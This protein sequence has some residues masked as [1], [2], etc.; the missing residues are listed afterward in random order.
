LDWWVPWPKF[1]KRYVSWSQPGPG[2]SHSINLQ[3]S[4]NLQ[5]IGESKDQPTAASQE[6]RFPLQT[7]LILLIMLIFHCVSDQGLT[8]S[9]AQNLHNSQNPLHVGSKLF[10]FHE[11]QAL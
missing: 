11:C 3:T 1:A 9:R 10:E 2:H 8:G 4:Q 6:N 5:W 7:M